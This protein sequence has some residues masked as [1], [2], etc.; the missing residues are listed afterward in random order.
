MPIRIDRFDEDDE[1]ELRAEGHTN[2]EILL[3]FLSANAEQAFTPKE[4]HEATE[5]PRGSVGVVLSRLEDRELVRHRGEY[6][7]IEPDAD[8]D[9]TLAAMSTARTASDRLGPEDPDDWGPGVE[10]D[11]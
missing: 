11:S 9:V 1:A 6:W 3:S 10:T 5:I 4:I 2:A 8:V 7:A